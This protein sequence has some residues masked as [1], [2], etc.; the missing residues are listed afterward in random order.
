[1]GAVGNK[2]SC[3]ARMSYLDTTIALGCAHLSAGQKHNKQRINELLD[4][5]DKPLFNPILK[6]VHYWLIYRTLN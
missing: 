6:Q 5:R 2:G 3:F 4:M 1:M